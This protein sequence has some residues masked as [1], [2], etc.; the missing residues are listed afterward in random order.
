MK[1]Y[2]SSSVVRKRSSGTAARRVGV[3]TPPGSLTCMCIKQHLQAIHYT[4]GYQRH[5]GK[6]TK[7]SGT[8]MF[9]LII[10]PLCTTADTSIPTNKRRR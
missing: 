7:D 8:C 3:E 2:K 1:N 6:I 5:P 4:Q 9:L 10:F